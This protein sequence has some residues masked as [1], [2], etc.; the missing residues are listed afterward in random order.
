[1]RVQ[2]P[3]K[4]AEVLLNLARPH[5]R[6]SAERVRSM[7]GSAEQDIQ[8][9]SPIW[10]HLT[11]QTAVVDNAGKL[12][13]RHDVYNLDSRTIAAIKNHRGSPEA[14]PQRK[15]EQ[16]A[17]IGSGPSRSA[18]WTRVGGSLASPGFMYR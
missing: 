9:P 17:T 7:F 12:Q 4:Y 8:L 5:E 11:Y 6:W 3:A 13:F 14:A 18:P 10:V 1:M 15:R 16:Q 2:D